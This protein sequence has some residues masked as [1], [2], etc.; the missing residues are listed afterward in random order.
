MK[1]E[2]L[3]LMTVAMGEILSVTSQECPA[4]GRI[5]F[6]RVKYRS[7]R[8]I[9]RFRCRRRYTLLGA[10]LSICLKGVWNHPAPVC[11]VPGCEIP[12]PP[13]YMIMTPSKND[14]LLTLECQP[15]YQLQG[16]ESVYCDGKKWSD[17][18]STCN[19]MEPAIQCDFENSQLCGWTQYRGDDFD[20]TINSSGTSTDRTGPDNDH[21]FGSA[22]NGHYLYM[23][24]SS[25]RSE[26]D[27]AIVLSPPYRDLPNGTCFE[28][29]YHMMGKPGPNE[30]GSLYVYVRRGDE[31]IEGMVPS[32]NVSEHQSPDWLR[33]S[34][35]IG[36]VNSSVQIVIT[37][38]RGRSYMGD[39]AID[40]VR[41][42][43][44]S[45]Q[46]DDVTTE[47]EIDTTIQWTTYI[48][49]V[50]SMVPDD[51]STF[52][53]IVTTDIPD[54]ITTTNILVTFDDHLVTSTS[55]ADVSTSTSVSNTTAIL[56]NTT[57]DVVDVTTE[58]STTENIMTEITSKPATS[59]ISTPKMIQ[60]PTTEVVTTNATTSST[61][62]TTSTT[63]TKATTTIRRTKRPSTT[64]TSVTTTPT[65]TTTT[66]STTTTTT[67]TTTTPPTTTTTTTKTTP[68]T[69]MSIPT[70]PKP[71]T[72]ATT[73][74]QTTTPLTST[75]KERKS[76]SP[77]TTTKTETTPRTR[78]TPTTTPITTTTLTIQSTRNSVA[79]E[80]NSNTS[81]INTARRSTTTISEN[82]IP[83]VT[84]TPQ[85]N[86]ETDIPNVIQVGKTS[87][88]SKGPVKPLMIGVGV[89]VAIGLAIVLV[90]VF[91]Y[92]KKH[93]KKHDDME[94]EM[95]P[96]ARNAYSEW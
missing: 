86:N 53:D 60:S 39:I 24:S 12:D 91:L 1:L 40:D 64:T 21:T 4:F 79:T 8:K 37:G 57:P 74:K 23:E 72:K 50:T 14:A 31:A 20:W 22:N 81:T 55:D 43:N 11:I 88:Q 93:R 92:M 15:G 68:T 44:C 3:V 66:M 47:S 58:S 29:Y 45:D 65:T 32:F 34:F 30:V 75:V 61:P 89:G 94:D 52:S 5:K 77:S 48:P 54:E 51:V 17:S 41:L 9:A 87:T 67:P 82:A 19:H 62:R 27:S 38:I 85:N 26:G 95:S 78:T 18:I 84:R 35:E 6:G 63:T 10:K 16:P 36:D 59:V 13:M 76:T 70:S 71:T 96:I 33:G 80:R 7:R 90:I 25:P 56:S 42:Y 49:E 73:L 83:E 69:T 46:V 2:I 28:F